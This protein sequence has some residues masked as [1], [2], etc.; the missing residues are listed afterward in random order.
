MAAADVNHSAS[1]EA[2][3]LERW[4]L[5][6]AWTAAALLGIAYLDRGWLAHDVGTLGHAAERVLAGELPH[7]D[8]VDVYTGGQAMVHA[9]AFRLFG[10]DVMTLRYVFF[11][12]YLLWIPIVWLVA[13]TFV[14]PTLAAVATLLA[15][16]LTLPVY[17]E[18]M[19]SWYNL[20]FAT[21]GAGALLRYQ[22]SRRA[23]WLVLAGLAGGVS[24]LFKVTGLYYVAAGLL[25]LLYLEGL[26]VGD[27][28]ASSDVG[29]RMLATTACGAMGALA[30]LVVVTGSGAAG[31]VHFALPPLA[32]VAVVAASLVESSDRSSGERLRRLA[33]MAGPFIAAVVVPIVVFSAPYALSGAL[34]ALYEGVF[35]LPRLRFEFAA[36][37]A[38]S[39]MGFVPA[40]GLV[41]WA[42]AAGARDSVTARL[43]V[44][45]GGVIIVGVV[46]LSH[47]DALYRVTW[48]TL[49]ALGPV[50]ATLGGWLL[51]HRG[52]SLA[53]GGDDVGAK[54]LLLL[55]VFGF[56]NLIQI[57]FS[58]PVYFLYAAPLL[59]LAALAITPPQLLGNRQP[60]GGRLLFVTV[61]I[62][63]FSVFRLDAGFLY[64]LGFRYR[65]HRQTEVLTLERVGGVRVTPEEKAEVE[66]LVQGLAGLETGPSILAIPDA[67]EV[68]FLTGLTNPTRTLFDFFES[69]TSRTE[70]VLAIVDEA[71]L[72]V[73]VLN[74]RRLFSPPVE[75]PLLDSLIARF[76]LAAE[77]G[78]FLI[79]WKG[80]ADATL[81]GSVGDP[82]L[83]GG[84]G[85]P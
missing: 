73:V 2:A 17:G 55:G 58:A 19:P 7:R 50:V 79:L 64:H 57:P 83:D 59:V 31:L 14:G 74:R 34:G 23:S 22:D 11:A 45:A 77:A 78:R 47:I 46:A 20:F 63:G 27:D 52:R 85:R 69:A 76:G 1:P 29:Y 15:A 67:P 28:D 81:S 21:A 62:L 13:R 75:G 9:F 68:Y 54:S 43:V 35:V 80:S 60:V 38:P 32:A 4:L 82:P 53:R 3:R 16:S 70:Q 71:D 12:A 18:A 65:P 49:R 8:Y 36:W 37:D 6:G 25:Y 48:W 42:A 56:C 41:A 51:L 39:M 30:L 61:V 40:A 44:L 66:R 84:S 72:Q 5:V 10:V 33:R 26:D 24:V